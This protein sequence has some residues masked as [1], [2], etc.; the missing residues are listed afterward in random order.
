MRALCRA[1]ESLAI[2]GIRHRHPRASE[3]EIR[4]RLAALRYGEDTMRRV[5]GWDPSVEGW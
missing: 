4:L 3:R 5:F 2:E 1:A